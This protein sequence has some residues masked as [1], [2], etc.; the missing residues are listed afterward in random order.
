[1]GPLSSLYLWHFQK[2]SLMYLWHKQNNSNKCKLI[3]P[4]LQLLFLFT[5]YN[6]K[7]Y[8]KTMVPI[9]FHFVL[10]FC[11]ATNIV[12][13]IYGSPILA[14]LC[15]RLQLIF[16]QLSVAVPV[17]YGLP[18]FHVTRIN[19]SFSINWEVWQTLR[20]SLSISN[21]VLSLPC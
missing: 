11:H 6:K 16:P 3:I 13:G 19:L 17:T 20:N 2:P 15:T 9:T 8:F 10:W 1:M 7:W 5:Q 4:H 21:L 12:T 18:N 14:N